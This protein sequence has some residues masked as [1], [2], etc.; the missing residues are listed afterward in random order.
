MGSVIVTKTVTGHVETET[1]VARLGVCPEKP[2]R[3]FGY[4]VARPGAVRGARS[5]PVPRVPLLI[6]RKIG[7]GKRAWLAYSVQAIDLIG[8]P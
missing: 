2:D 8:A 3:T 7:E 4:R 6:W 5:K 1:P